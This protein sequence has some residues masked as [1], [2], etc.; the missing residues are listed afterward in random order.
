MQKGQQLLGE[1]IASLFGS[2]GLKRNIFL[3]V[4]VPPTA[5]LVLFT[6]AGSLPRMARA[7][8]RSLP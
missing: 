4:A 3:R 1:R 2:E 7:A 8:S 5:E 6:F